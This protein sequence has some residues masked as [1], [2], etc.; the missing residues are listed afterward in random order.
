MTNGFYKNDN[1]S[2]LYAPN[3]V[4]NKDYELYKEQKDTYTYPVEGWKWFDDEDSAYTEYGLKKPE[5]KNN[6]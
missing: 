2:V 5:V 4:I 6:E 1:G 3:F